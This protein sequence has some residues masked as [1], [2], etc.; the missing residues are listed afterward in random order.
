M[1]HN[2]ETL[3]SLEPF[4]KSTIHEH[5]PYDELFNRWIAELGLDIHDA[6]TVMFYT[7]LLPIVERRVKSC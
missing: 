3:E 1:V 6:D 2:V 7:S 5:L 4:I